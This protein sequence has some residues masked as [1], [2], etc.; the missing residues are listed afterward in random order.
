MVSLEKLLTSSVHLGHKVQ[1]WNPKM[2]PYIYGERNGVHIIDLLQTL[3]CLERVCFFLKN[4]KKNKNNILFVSTKPQ[5]ASVIQ[6]YALSSGS[7][8]VNQRWLGGM[9]TNWS[10]I[11]KCISSLQVLI[12]QESDGS[13]DRLSKKEALLLKKRKA[14]LERYFLGLLNMNNLPDVVILIGQHRELNAV[15]ECIKLKI[16]LITI[17]D[18]NCDPT[19]TDFLVPANDDSI[20]SVSLILEEF[21]NSI[22]V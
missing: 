12:K 15:K 2:S 3:I 8:Y 4:T 17:L 22:R 16:P 6:S 7:H 11:K 21:C 1:Q 20:S 18:T 9:L 14:K 5:F 19:L 10:T 13:W